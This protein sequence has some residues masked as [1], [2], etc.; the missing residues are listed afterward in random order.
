[1][2]PERFQKPI[3]PEIKEDQTLGQILLNE[4]LVSQEQINE[5][6][7][8][9]QISRTYRPIGQ[10]LVEQGAITL[11][12]L[13]FFLD[14]FRKRPQ[15]GEILVRS[16]LISEEVLAKALERTRRTKQRLGEALVESNFITEE[17]MRQT[18]CA[19]LNI[20]FID[21]SRITIDRHLAKFINKNFAQRHS[22]V[23]I[24]RLGRTVT[25]AMEDPTNF[26]LVNELQDLTGLVIN[27][28]TST[29]VAIANAFRQLYE[30]EAVESESAN[31]QLAEEAIDED[32]EG[33]EMM[34]L[35]DRQM[36]D[37][38]VKQIVSLGL[39]NRASDIHIESTEKRVFLR[40]RIDGVLQELYLG[41][42]EEELNRSRKEVISRIKILGKL[43]ISERR[44]PQD[45][46]FRIHLTKQGTQVSI[47]FR[48]SIV[49][50]YYGEN[51]V[52]R[53]LDARNAPRSIDELG[54]S[55]DI[56]K[57]I[58]DLLHRNSG[59]LLVTGP[60]GSGKSTT[61]YGALMSAYRPGV[62]I[63]TAEN[64]I[65][66]VYDKITQCE[67]NPKIGNTFASLVRAFLRQDPEIILVGEIRDTDTAEMAFRAAQTG[68]LVLSTLHTNDA[69]SSVTR[70]SGIGVELNL[71]ANSLIGVL[72]QRLVRKICQRCKAPYLPSAEILREFFENNPPNITWMKGQGC[73]A[74][75]Q[76]GYKGRIALAELWMPSQNDM[77]LINKGANFEDLRVSAAKSTVF[78]WQDAMEK[79]KNGQTDL[80]ELIRM[81]PYTNIFEF[82][83]AD[84]MYPELWEPF[85]KLSRP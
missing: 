66:Y 49:P 42:M 85:S 69:I 32:L 65:E 46:S 64:P 5:A 8:S 52:L 12:Q 58:V 82:R 81:L 47:D 75:N 78:M 29:R 63:L 55:E 18:L 51:V 38:L 84:T 40:Y 35:K 14:R 3:D 59:I 11:S 77:I 50:A 25:L 67:V 31:V 54:F 30:N 28:V 16:G 61:L 20:P 73:S 45:G 27:V 74:C 9:Q 79:L 72:S 4:G 70:L 62:K 26:E 71:I 83:H 2:Q 39:K 60:T 57:N 41:R 24:A 6:R 43:D 48:I 37:S 15:L 21:F 10:L 17:A 19:Q 7:R 80:E 36:A 22:I 53:I 23:P 33:S 1:M 76:T 56:R 68:H 34:E 13:N 44:R